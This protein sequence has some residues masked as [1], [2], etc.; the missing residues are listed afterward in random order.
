MDK[1]K[2]LKEQLSEKLANL[3]NNLDDQK[4]RY[5]LI[6]LTV[7]MFLLLGFGVVPNVRANIRNKQIHSVLSSRLV[8]GENFIA[9][10]YQG[11]KPLI[12]D[13]NEVTLLFV[14]PNGKNYSNLVKVIQDE[15]KKEGMTKKVYVYPLIYDIKETKRFFNLTSDVT[16]I[17]FSNQTEVRRVSFTE[18]QEIDLYFMDHLESV[19]QPIHREKSEE[20]TEETKTSNQEAE[21]TEGTS[22]EADNGDVIDDLK[23]P[24][25]AGEES[26]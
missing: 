21:T 5:I 22:E 15:K 25:A 23:N 7:V 24:E 16:L 26:L 8:D 17:H 2:H 12:L 11:A 1:I 18:P 6:A 19:R 3:N 20:K 4:K 14:D 9:V 10:D 13:K